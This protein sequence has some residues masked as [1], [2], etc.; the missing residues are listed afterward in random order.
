MRAIFQVLVQTNQLIL[1]VPDFPI[2]LK[3]AVVKTNQT[4]TGFPG[5]TI[6]AKLR[7]ALVSNSF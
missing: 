5:S 6:C 2:L 3:M 7:S 4:C 1:L